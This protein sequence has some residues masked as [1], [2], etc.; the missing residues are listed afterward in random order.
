LAV[1][2]KAQE[3]A[4]LLINSIQPWQLTDFLKQVSPGGLFF[5]VDCES[6]IEAEEL[7]AGLRR[8]IH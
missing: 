8:W 3:H 4:K 5:I 2:H 7:I 6:Q 1:C